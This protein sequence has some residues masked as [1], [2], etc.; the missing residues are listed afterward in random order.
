MKGLTLL[1]LSSPVSPSLSMLQ[2]NIVETG[3]CKWNVKQ[4]KGEEQIIESIDPRASR[5]RSNSR[6]EKQNNVE[7]KE[8]G[9]QQGEVLG[10]ALPRV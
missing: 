2:L 6:G 7:T 4:E 10:W 3:D 1:T 9:V 8:E 5:Q